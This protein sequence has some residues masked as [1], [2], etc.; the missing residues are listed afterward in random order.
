MSPLATH[1]LERID[2]EVTKSPPEGKQSVVM[3]APDK[4]ARGHMVTIIGTQDNVS[5]EIDR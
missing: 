3:E 5:G 4:M 1:A 2:R